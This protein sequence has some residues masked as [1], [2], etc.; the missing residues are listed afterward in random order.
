M[1]Y[2]LPIVIL[3]RFGNLVLINVVSCFHRV[4]ESLQSILCTD[5]ENLVL[6]YVSLHR[7]G[8]K[9]KLLAIQD[10]LAGDTD[11]ANCDKVLKHFHSA[12]DPSEQK[13]RKS[14][15]RSF[16]L[17]VKDVCDAGML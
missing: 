12:C 10:L 9:R 2:M 4:L 13:C 17:T 6:I 11:V 14:N 8:I 15:K 5:L 3:C 7:V 16:Q 1:P